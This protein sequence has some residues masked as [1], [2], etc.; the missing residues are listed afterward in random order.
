MESWNEDTVGW[1]PE[2]RILLPRGVL[3]QEEAVQVQDEVIDNLS[4]FEDSDGGKGGTKPG[5]MAWH[6][7]RKAWSTRP[8]A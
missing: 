5:R 6:R 2:K 3:A 7:L 8:L 4:A 1:L